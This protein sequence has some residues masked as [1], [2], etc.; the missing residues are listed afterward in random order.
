MYN[1]KTL[2]TLCLGSL[3]A[4]L[5]ACQ[6]DAEDFDS[7]AFNA[8]S[9]QVDNL[10]LKGTDTAEGTLL[11]QLAQPIDKTCHITYTIAP[12]LLDHYRAVYKPTESVEVL[13]ADFYDFPNAVSIIPQGGVQGSAV[14]VQFKHLSQLD[15]SKVYLLPVQASS[16]DIQ[17]LGSQSVHFF[18]LKGAALIN[19]VASGKENFF[20]FQNT[21]DHPELNGLT[22][23]TIEALVRVDKFG[24]LI[25]TIMGREGAFLLRAGDAGIPDNQ[26]QLATSLGNVTDAAWTLDAGKWTHIA[27]TIDANSGDVN[28]YLNGVKKGATHRCPV[29]M[30]NWDQT[31]DR[32]FYIGYSYAGDRYLDGDFSECRVWKRVLSA[33][34]IQS[35]DHFYQVDPASE[36]LVAYW[37]FDEGEGSIIKDATANRYHLRSGASVK[38]SEVELPAKN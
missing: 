9:T 34:E 24:R 2:A 20:T 5:P 30:I 29:S 31:G 4:L 21:S 35:K 16:S 27:M 36:G 32:G 1:Y 26:L 19:T 7:L 14:M 17:L 6:K 22:Q 25:S 37:K 3:L 18:V 23:M 13:S 12:A 15:R 10:L 8:N 33:E 11:T 28:L 38:W